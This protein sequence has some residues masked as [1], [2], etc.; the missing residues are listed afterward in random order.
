MRASVRHRVNVQWWYR[1]ANAQHQ[2]LPQSIFYAFIPFS[3]F[4]IRLGRRSVASVSN[5][6]YTK[7]DRF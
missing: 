1:R 5:A 6:A 2:F 4:P 7:K 3:F